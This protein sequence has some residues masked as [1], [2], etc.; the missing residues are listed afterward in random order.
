MSKDFIEEANSDRDPKKKASNRGRPLNSRTTPKPDC[1]V[2][3]PLT[4]YER[5]AIAS[6]SEKTGVPR[7]GIIKRFI[8]EGL[9]NADFE[10]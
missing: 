4:K 1:F 6:I 9:L 8:K 7:R 3:I 2:N 5:D 10:L